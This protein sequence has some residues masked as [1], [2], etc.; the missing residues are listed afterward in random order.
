MFASQSKAVVEIV[1]VGSSGGDASCYNSAA[2]WYVCA[3]VSMFTTEGLKRRGV[4]G[5]R[6]RGRNKVTAKECRGAALRSAIEILWQQE[7]Y[8]GAQRRVKFYGM[9]CW[10]QAQGALGEKATD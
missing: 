6:N 3:G 2:I 4:G 8:P 9:V 10:N 1:E 5:T 7:D